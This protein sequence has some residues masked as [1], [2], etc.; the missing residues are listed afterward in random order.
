MARFEA[1]L[2]NNGFTNETQTPA[3]LWIGTGQRGHSAASIQL[4]LTPQRICGGN[5]SAAD[6]VRSDRNFAQLPMVR[7]LVRLMYPD[8]CHINIATPSRGN[9]IFGI[10]HDGLAATLRGNTKLD[11]VL[12][13]LR[14]EETAGRARSWHVRDSGSKMGPAQHGRI[15]IWEWREPLGT[16]SR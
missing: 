5:L 13:L 10:T 7:E 3:N 9:S 15:L 11:A 16:K 8:A 4:R 12:Q 6:E 2:K 14:D 1:L